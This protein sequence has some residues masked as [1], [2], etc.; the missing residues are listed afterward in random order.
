MKTACILWCRNLMF[1]LYL[2]EL[3]ALKSQEGNKGADAQRYGPCGWAAAFVW[4]VT[5][6]FIGVARGQET[7]WRVTSRSVVGVVCR[8]RLILTILSIYG[9]T[10]LCCTSAAFSVGRTPWKG[11]QPVAR[12]LPTYGT[13]QTQNK[14]TR[15][16]PCLERDLNPRFQGLSGRRQFMP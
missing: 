6:T 2:G 16:H 7:D 8:Y 15:R 11:D 5:V 14:R 12:P 4:P 3:G 13:A 1:R 10:A 9:S